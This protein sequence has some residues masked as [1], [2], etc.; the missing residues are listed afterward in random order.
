MAASDVSGLLPVLDSQGFIWTGGTGWETRN[1][2]TFRVSFCD[3]LMDSS[4]INEAHKFV[5]GIVTTVWL[6]DQD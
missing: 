3:H 5:W 2:E 4:A 1:F 6:M